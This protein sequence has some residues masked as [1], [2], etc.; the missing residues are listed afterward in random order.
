MKQ[1]IFVEPGRLD[2]ADVPK[3]VLQGDGE[4]IVR[5]RI[6]GRCDLDV[7][8]LAG[9]M[10]LARGE[11][12]G[13]E[14]IGEIVELG[15]RAARRFHVGQNVIVPAQISCGQCRM[16]AAGESGRCENV[17][18]GASYGMGRAGKFG[19][20]LSDLV[21]VPFARA[22]LVPLSANATLPSMIGLADMA[23]DAWRAVGPQLEA[24]PGGTV[25]VMGGATPV[26]GLYAAALA[27]CLGAGRVA[28][29]D[30]DESRRA[31]ADDYGVESFAHVDA[32]DRPVFDIVVDAA[33]DQAKLL[34]AIRACAPAAQLTSVAPP[35]ASPELPLLE[36]YHKGLNYRIGRPNCRHGH[37]GAMEAWAAAGFQPEKVGPKL[38]PF[39]AAAEAWMDPALYVAVQRD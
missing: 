11:P 39:D 14:V 36:M 19:G 24:R 20:G 32:I 13:H 22:M 6:V 17:P 38:F 1:L 16:C 18:F 3:P 34:A 21:R 2:W 8:Y 7:L 33:H 28:Y 4:A 23:T 10:P 35:F 27:R 25:L 30:E 37:S 5:P 26:I 9:R 12:I 29:V 31:V 15:E